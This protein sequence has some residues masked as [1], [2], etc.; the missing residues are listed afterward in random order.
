MREDIDS[1]PSPFEYFCKYMPMELFEEISNFT[2]LYSFKIWNVSKHNCWRKSTF[3]FPAHYYGGSSI[4][5]FGFTLESDDKSEFG[6]QHW[7]AK[8]SFL[9]TEELST[10]SGFRLSP[11]NTWTCLEGGTDCIYF[12]KK[13]LGNYPWRKSMYRWV[14]DSLQR[15]AQYKAVHKKQAKSLGDKFSCYVDNLE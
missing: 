4:S 10:V 7:N 14:H 8:E 13:I 5:T 2:N 6:W 12:W 15:P 11:W 1:I 3:I 9:E